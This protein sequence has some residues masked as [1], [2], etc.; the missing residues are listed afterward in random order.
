[1]KSALYEGAVVHRRLVPRPHAFRTRL[2]MVYLDLDELPSVFE[3]RLLWSAERRNLVWF[4]RA[5]YMAPH[6]RPLREVVL[7]RVEA[8]TGRRP[9][10]A[11]RML[12]HLRTFGYVFNPVTFY[13]CFDADERLEAIVSEITNTPWFERHAYVHDVRAAQAGPARPET[14]EPTS[15]RDAQAVADGRRDGALVT[16]RFAKDF[17]VSP[18]FGMD[19]DH[20]WRFGEPGERLDV[21]M[22]NVQ[23]G[24]AVFHAGLA[25]ERR[26]L[27]GRVL[28][29]A[30]LVHPLLTL[31]VHAAIYV[32]AGLL[33]LKRTPFF[34]HAGRGEPLSDTTT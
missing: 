12:T 6:D 22:T 20:V 8:A 26:P 4:R 3:R 14:D 1:V 29:R 10:G 34:A 25:L 31:R 24:R 28:A 32:Q 7:D 27:T 15:P 5:D 11:V 30:L 2:F 17:H 18:F 9:A 33:W 19:L 13:Y 16:W 23:G 21:H